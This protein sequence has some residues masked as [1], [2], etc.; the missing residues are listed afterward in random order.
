[1]L[2]L[3]LPL[4]P[5]EVRTPM[6]AKGSEEAHKFP[7]RVRVEPGRQRYSGAFQA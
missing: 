3:P 2:Q 7:Q 1:M 6:A 5:L 4:L